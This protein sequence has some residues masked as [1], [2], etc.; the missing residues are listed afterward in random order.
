MSMSQGLRVKPSTP[1]VM[2]L[3]RSIPAQSWSVLAKHWRTCRKLLAVW[4]LA[5]RLVLLVFRAMLCLS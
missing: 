2:H 5:Q 1:A 3:A 4:R